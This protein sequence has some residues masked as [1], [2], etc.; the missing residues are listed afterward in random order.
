M[1]CSDD[2]PAPTDA[3]DTLDD[4]VAAAAFRR[5]VRLLQHRSDAANIDLKAFTQDFY[6]HVAMGDLQPVLDTLVYLR[7]ETDVWF[8][9]T[10]LLMPGHNDS[11]VEL[12]AMTRWIHDELGADVPL[13]F[14]AFHP[15]FK[16]MDTPATP[17]STL[18]R[19]REI[20]LGNGLHF[21]YTG[22]VHDTAGSSTYCPSCGAR[23]VERDWYV[24]GEYALSEDGHCEHCGTRIAGRF[25]GP[26]GSWGARRVPVRLKARR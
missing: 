23:V 3:L 7:H 21:V 24:L 2:T 13:H 25:D 15:D 18:T 17:P 14:T 26:P 6:R 10:N 5:L 12:D 19:A 22:N 16:M 4:A 11:D 8:E 9:I 20:A 1:S